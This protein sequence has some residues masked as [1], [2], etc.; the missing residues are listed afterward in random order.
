MVC[1]REQGRR[2]QYGQL[3]EA[4]GAQLVVDAGQYGRGGKVQYASAV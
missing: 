3:A 2:S 4:P 1:W